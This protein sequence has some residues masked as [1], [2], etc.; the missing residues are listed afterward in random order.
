M[1]NKRD[2]YEVL[3]VDKKA[4]VEE[5]K[6]AYRKLAIQYHPDRQHDKSEAEKKEAEEKFK[7]AAE[8][9][10]VL[11][12]ADKRARYD[13]FGF[14]AEQ[15][16]GGGGGFGGFD[17]NDILNQVFG[18]GF[19]FGGFSGFGGFGGGQ[20]Q[21]V[22]RG[23]DLRVRVRV[24]LADVAHGVE[25]KL[26]IPRQVSCQACRGTG[27]K[28]GTALETCSTCHGSGVEVRTRR[29]MFGVMQQQAACQTCGGTGKII[30]E[31]CHDCGGH[32]LTRKEEVISVN[33]PAGVAEGMMLKMSNHGNDAPGGGVPGDLLIVIEETAD[34]QLVREGNDIIY[35]LMLDIPTAVF[36]GKVDVPTVDGQARVTIKPGTQPG[37]VLRLRGKGLPDPNRYGKGDELINV[38]VY[39]PEAL[40]ADERRAFELLRD[41]QSGNI[42]PTESTRSRIFSRLRHIFD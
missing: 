30:K 31:R 37:T 34:T 40:N 12:D 18:G 36:G 20:G 24:T 27:A 17:I 42:K 14:A 11:S 13:Q 4:T 2:Y 6:K 41:S 5:I 33:I 9:Y 25:K 19:N 1:A 3:G 10:S 7:E 23:T 28:N 22:N 32:G 16:G 15:M 38:M 35:N 39:V 29:T 26:K 8:A 21:R